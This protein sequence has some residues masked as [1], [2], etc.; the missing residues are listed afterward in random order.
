M[1]NSK[2]ETLRNIPSVNK[3]IERR[4]A[5]WKQDSLNASFY[6]KYDYLIEYTF[7]CAI[8]PLKRLLYAEKCY[9]LL[10]DDGILKGIFLP[11]KNESCNNPPYHVSIDDIKDVFSNFFEIIKNE[12]DINSIEPRFGNEVYIEMIKKWNINIK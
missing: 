6:N 7:F 8:D 12:L 4:C 5:K 9:E 11:L 3:I 2:N 1:T 10:K